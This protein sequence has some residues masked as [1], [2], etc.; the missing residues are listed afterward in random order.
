[1]FI[2]CAFSHKY[3]GNELNLYKSASA[4]YDDY[5]TS[6]SVT[7]V[8]VSVPS[9][10]VS[11]QVTRDVFVQKI[12]PSLTASYGYTTWSKHSDT[13]HGVKKSAILV[14]EL[15]Y[16]RRNCQAEGGKSPSLHTQ[17]LEC[18]TFLRTSQCERTRAL[19]I[20]SFQDKQHAIWS[21]P[22]HFSKKKKKNPDCQSLNSD[23][24]F[25]K[26]HQ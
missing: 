12:R 24:M 5:C 10:D 25:M 23:L 11:C 20:I 19:K 13:T 26:S 7:V 14:S 1:M 21:T 8:L 22:L 9:P 6:T 4:Q 18:T 17:C 2:S 15:G 16:Y 3:T